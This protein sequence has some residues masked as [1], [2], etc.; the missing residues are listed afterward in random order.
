MEKKLKH[1]TTQVCVEVGFIIKN[2]KIIIEF[3][4]GAFSSYAE[5]T[6]HRQTHLHIII[7]FVNIFLTKR[8]FSAKKIFFFPFVLP[9]F[10]HLMLIANVLQLHPS[11]LLRCYSF[12]YLFFGESIWDSFHFNLL[13]AS[14]PGFHILFRQCLESSS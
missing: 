4:V 14:Q 7:H 1:L 2:I 6:L 12:S 10:V 5:P 13:T 9:P 11:L 3:E 8:T